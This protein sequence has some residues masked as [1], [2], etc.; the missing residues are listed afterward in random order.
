M[1]SRIHM[2]SSGGESQRPNAGEGH[3][4]LDSGTCE[5]GT[6]QIVQYLLRY[7]CSEAQLGLKL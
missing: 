4:I 1:N 2:A 6:F 7:P 5:L 3:E